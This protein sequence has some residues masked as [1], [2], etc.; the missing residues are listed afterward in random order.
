VSTGTNAPRRHLLDDARRVHGEG[1]GRAVA[2]ETY[3]GDTF[4]A[5]DLVAPL[6]HRL[7]RGANSDTVAWR[8]LARSPSLEV[9][10]SSM[11]DA[12]VTTQCPTM[13]LPLG[14]LS[15]KSPTL[16]PCLIMRH[17][18]AQPHSFLLAAPA[19]LVVC[20]PLAPGRKHFGPKQRGGHP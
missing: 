8:S 2:A 17:R 6:Q 16:R 1:A 7:I 9:A 13:P 11:S 3:T 18:P 19:R 15:L 4:L 14:E 20:V 10:S 5:R 12:S